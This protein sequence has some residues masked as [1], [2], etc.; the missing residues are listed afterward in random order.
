MPP[1]AWI[2]LGIGVGL[3]VGN[4]LGDTSVGLGV[5]A[6]I[7]V[8]MFYVTQRRNNENNKDKE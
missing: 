6:A 8:T 2:A 1:P 3:A 5:G 7:G 4:A